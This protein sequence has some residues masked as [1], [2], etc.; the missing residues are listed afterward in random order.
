MLSGALEQRHVVVPQ[1]EQSLR[2]LP[3]QRATTARRREGGLE[4]VGGPRVEL[5]AAKSGQQDDRVEV[6]S[7]TRW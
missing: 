2:L 7:T 6:G 4:F 5:A 1:Q 3:L